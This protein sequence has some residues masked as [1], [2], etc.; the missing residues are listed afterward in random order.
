MPTPVPPEE[1]VSHA[2]EE[3]LRAAPQPADAEDEGR[4]ATVEQV[5]RVA[6]VDPDVLTGLPDRALPAGSDPATPRSAVGECPA[7][8]TEPRPV[9]S[10]GT[11]PVT[12]EQETITAGDPS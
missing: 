8:S 5:A 12:L 1:T 10:I 9:A 11:S 6:G 4:L 2:P 7:T 3:F